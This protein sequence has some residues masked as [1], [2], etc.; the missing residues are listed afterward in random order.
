MKR[1]IAILSY[2]TIFISVLPAP[3]DT[4]KLREYGSLK[5]RAG[6]TFTGSYIPPTND[7]LRG[8]NPRK[9]PINTSLAGTLR[10]DFSFGND[11]RTGML[12]RGLYQ[13]IGVGINSFLA[14]NELGNPGSVFVYQGAPFFTLPYGLTLD[15]E[16]RFGAA[17]GWKHRDDNDYATSDNSVVSTPVT[18]LMSIALRLSYRIG[19][20]IYLS[21][22]I[23]GTHFSNGN[24]SWP[25]AGLNSIGATIGVAYSLGDNGESKQADAALKTEADRHSWF[26]DVVAYGAI[27][28]RTV[29]LNNGPNLCPGR[30]GVAGLQVMPMY[31]LNRFVAI[32][33]AL[34]MQW[35]EGAGLAPYWV[36]NTSGDCIRFYRPPFTRQISAG[37]SA[38]AELTMPIFAVNAG[39]GF[40]FINPQGNNRFYQSLT[41]KTFITRN[42]FINTGYRL[43]DFKAPQNL[44]LGFGYRF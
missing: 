31:R 39:I 16:W 17:F 1:L 12:Y 22:G 41:L 42:L 15:Y 3:R 44:M 24:T 36:D 4:T 34:D 2:L 8:M 11:S 13:G 14:K 32:G 18:A 30:F 9:T 5:W 37:I 7:F 35:D 43:G 27:R 26:Y 20:R 21:A 29:Y 33:P 6:A 40:D 25:N 38:H 28:K 23:E 19:Q 10:A